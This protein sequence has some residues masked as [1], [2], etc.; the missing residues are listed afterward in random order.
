MDENL[1]PAAYL[2][3]SYFHQ[4]CLLDDPDW[5]SVIER[6]KQ[7]ESQE[8]IRTT[9]DALLRLL[10][11]RNDREVEAFLFSEGGSCFDPRTDGLSCRAWVEDI[12]HLLAGGSSRPSDAEGVATARKRA[13]E[14]VRDILSGRRSL[15]DRETLEKKDLEISRA[16]LWARE[17]GQTALENVRRRFEEAG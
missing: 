11:R 3:G 10:Q 8:N 17:V 1:K 7:S 9:R 2:F 14:I 12:V 16:R 15:W 5:Q 13:L 4:D 6:F